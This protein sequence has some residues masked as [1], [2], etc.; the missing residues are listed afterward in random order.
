MQKSLFRRS[1]VFGIILLFIGLSVTSSING[2]IGKMSNQ[3]PEEAPINFPLNNDYV[4]AYWKF[5][6]CSG[7]IAYDSSGHDYDG[8]IYGA[9]WV[10]GPSGCALD[11]DGVNDYVDLDNHSVGL[12]F[13]K[14]DDLIFS[15]WFNST[16]I[17]DGLIYSMSDSLGE[18]SPEFSIQL[19][20]NGSIL[21]KVWT[22]QYKPYVYSDD[23]FNDGLW[24]HIKIIFF[25][26]TAKP[27]LQLYVDNEF[28]AEKTEW[29]SPFSADD[30]KKAKIGRRAVNA[31]KHFDGIIDEF[32][33]I[34]YPSGDQGPE[35]PI[36]T[37]PTFGM[38]GEKLDYTFVTEDP[39]GDDIWYQ[40]NWGDG[41]ETSW[42]GPYESG[43]EIIRSHVYSKNGIYEI[44]ARAKDIW[45]EGH[46]SYP[47]L[48]IIG[49][50][51]PDTPT[52]DGPTSGK[53]GVEYGY[54]FTSTD[55]NG[56]NVYYYI[57]WGDNDTEEWIGPYNSDEEITVNHSWSEE[58][59]YMIKAKAEDIYGLE[60]D[61]GTLEV[62]M[63]KS[64][65]IHFNFN[66]L[67]WLFERFPNA[68]P[69]LRY[70]LGL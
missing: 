45:D 51:P 20:S 38:P 59:T 49:Y 67:S 29:L 26:S 47:F 24:H 62:T 43:E 28:E 16:S 10:G 8:T 36:I 54:T 2:H 1:L 37:G 42:I 3:L 68:F 52:I 63:P 32:K 21:F 64:K 50:R 27:T 14:T 11:F 48:V 19:C 5:D 22:N 65:T 17:D 61:W 44:K 7:N 53:G 46:W 6:E 58:G 70:M 18:Q 4:N 66:L 39:E 15:V 33:Y 55:P 30:F 34:K 13:N 31:T 41:N 35:P 40:I 23:A 56:D 12:G 60:S 25:G 57:E 9:S 69:I